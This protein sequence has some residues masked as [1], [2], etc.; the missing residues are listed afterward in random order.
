MIGVVPVLAT[1][2]PVMIIASWIGNW[3]FYV[4]HQFEDTY[5]DQEGDWDFHTA[6]LSGSSYFKLPPILQWFSGNI[7]LHHV[8]HLCSRIPNYR[9]QAFLDTAPELQRIAESDIAARELEMLA[10][11]AVGRAAP[12]AG[13]IPRSQASGTPRHQFCPLRACDHHSQSVAHE[14]AG[15]RPWKSGNMMDPDG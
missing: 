7:G 4:Q 14:L 13:R 6:A 11:D 1:Y 9:L 10:P 2:L 5:W 15:L 12:L 8:H 3:L